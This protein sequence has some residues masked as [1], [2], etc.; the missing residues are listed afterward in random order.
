MTLI[1]KLMPPYCKKGA[2]D[3]QKIDLA[4][5][6]VSLRELADRLNS[7]WEDILDYPLVD[8]RGQLTA[9]FTVNGNSASPDRLVQDGDRVTVI[10]YICGG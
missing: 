3:E 8:S 4:D 2:P 6:P 9:E 7:E 5:Q 1:I 10:P